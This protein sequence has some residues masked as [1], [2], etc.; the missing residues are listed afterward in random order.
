MDSIKSVD[1]AKK[2]SIKVAIF[3][4]LKRK[5]KPHRHH[6]YLEVVVLFKAKGTHYIDQIAYQV[7][8][9]IA[10][11]IRK[12]Q[13][14]YWDLGPAPEGI[15]ILIKDDFLTDC[16]DPVIKSLLQQLSPFPCLIPNEVEVLKS[17]C[18]IIIHAFQTT[19]NRH[20]REGL[21]KAF[22]AALH[23]Y[24]N[25]AQSKSTGVNALCNQFL[26]LLW[27]KKVLGIK[28][29]DYATRLNTTPQ[30]LTQLC[31]KETGRSAAEIIAAEI[32]S[33]AIRLLFYSE[34]NIAEISHLLG[35]KDVSHFIKFFK[36]AKGMTPNQFRRN[37]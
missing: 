22:L 3:D 9:P 21:L 37:P 33:E 8:R 27:R 23:Q 34:N 35:F 32:T 12:D 24:S 10:F 30:N 19:S 7:D 4:P 16:E 31:K 36:R 29:V 15:V 2:Q 13:V 11:N 20:V 5:T 25:V 6:N 18:P 26:K 1:K 14:H 17:L 28:V